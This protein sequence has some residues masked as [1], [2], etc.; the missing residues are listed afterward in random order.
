MFLQVGAPTTLTISFLLMLLGQNTETGKSVSRALKASMEKT[1]GF[2]LK[3]GPDFEKK[4]LANDKSGLFTFLLPDDKNHRTFKNLLERRKASEDKSASPTVGSDLSDEESKKR[5]VDLSFIIDMPPISQRD[6][7]IIRLTAQSVAANDEGYEEAFYKHVE[8]IGK[9]I[10]FAFLHNQHTYHPLYKHHLDWYRGIIDYSNGAASKFEEKII[11]ALYLTEDDLLSRSFDRA[12]YEKLAR[13][14]KRKEEAEIMSRQ[15]HYASI[16]WQDFKFVARVNFDTIDDFSEL[17]API[18]QKEV[19]ARSLAVRSKRLELPHDVPAQ[20]SREN[21]NR[22]GGVEE[23]ESF[24]ALNEPMLRLNSEALNGTS[25][26]Q[27]MK[28]MKIKAAGEKRLMRSGQNRGEI[29]LTSPSAGEELEQKYD[30]HLRDNMR[31]PRYKEQQDNYLRKN[32]TYTSNLTTEKV[33]ENINNLVRRPD[34]SEEE[35]AAKTK[36]MK[37]S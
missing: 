25:G 23:D 8:R 37:H 2:I 17:A 3:N 6:L 30:A 1:I 7:K 16:D 22:P 9:G 28:G 24:S 20:K 10:Q 27:P 31:H 21:I 19:M 13:L 12:S 5:P 4:L 33:H 18:S 11:D 29:T 26:H 34:E 36:K 14:S 35:E 32:F 15:E